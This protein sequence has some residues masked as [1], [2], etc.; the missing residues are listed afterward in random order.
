M[1]FSTNTLLISIKQLEEKLDK[2]KRV[3]EMVEDHTKMPHKHSDYYERLCCLA[4]RSR[5]VLEE[6]FDG[7]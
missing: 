6:V 1:E 3:L 2:C 4:E 7:N 5:E